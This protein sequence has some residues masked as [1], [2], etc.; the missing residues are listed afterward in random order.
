MGIVNMYTGVYKTG[1]NRQPI[2][3]SAM[4]RY[5]RVQEEQ[6]S[7]PRRWSGDSGQ[8]TE[9]NSGSL[10]IHSRSPSVQ[11]DNLQLHDLWLTHNNGDEDE[12]GYEVGDE[13]C[14][15][16]RNT[17]IDRFFLRN[18]HRIGSRTAKSLR[19][20]HLVMERTM[21]VL[22]FVALA[23][24]VVVY[25]GI[26]VSASRSGACGGAFA[27]NP[28]Q[29]DSKIFGGMA[30]FVKGGIFFWYGLLT[31]G[32]WLGCFADFGWAWNRKPSKELVGGLRA[33]VPTAE[34]VEST[35]IAV[36]GASNVFMEHMAAWGEAWSAQDLE[37]ISI[38]VMFLGG[39]LVSS[40]AIHSV[41]VEIAKSTC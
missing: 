19:V 38:T 32:R 40:S 9:R 11:S 23:S 25:A 24:G 35:V 3:V 7:N 22:G 1:A 10:F 15:M 26:F 21:L 17:H 2:S 28:C 6:N 16:L 4:T 5:E 39:G 36:Y 37:H 31:F 34:F 18:I 29:H 41:F 33:S 13:K 14:G 12:D 27:N 30:H 8:G 20:L